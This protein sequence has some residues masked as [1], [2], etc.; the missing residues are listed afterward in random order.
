MPWLKISKP[1]TIGLITFQYYK[2]KEASNED[3]QKLY[4]EIDF[5]FQHYGDTDGQP[6][7]NVVICKHLNEGLLIKN[8]QQEENVK[9]ARNILAFIAINRRI[10]TIVKENID[11]LPRVDA[12]CSDMFQL[13]NRKITGK[14]EFK[15]RAGKNQ[16]W[17]GDCDKPV[18]WQ[19]WETLHSE[20]EPNSIFIDLVNLFSDWLNSPIGKIKRM[21]ILRGLDL[22][23]QAHIES[24]QSDIFSKVVLMATVFEILLGIG[25]GAKSI[26]IAEKLNRLC[27]NNFKIITR[28][29]GKKKRFSF[30][31]L[32]W[33]G[34]SFYKLRNKFVHGNKIV[35]RDMLY[36]KSVPHIN[37]A[38]LV[39]KYAIICKI[40]K[41]SR[42]NIWKR[43]VHCMSSIRYVF[44]KLGWTKSNWKSN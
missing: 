15:F 23:Y 10:S 14:M 22:F 5:I 26:K 18:I 6:L 2:R 41:D 24:I 29:Y 40:L 44:R 9:N 42:T 36:T 33:W 35:L 38:D 12:I 30:S 8:A 7:K 20:I 32:S 31:K 1:I 34:Y 37:L 28:K 17:C 13:A 25:K 39:F 4:D 19:P 16:I 43:H 21:R 3:S 27:I 11:G